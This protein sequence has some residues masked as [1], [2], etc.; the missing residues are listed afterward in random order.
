MSPLSRGSATLR[1]RTWKP[2]RLCSGSA[3]SGA[4]APV[5]YLHGPGR[6]GKSTLLQQFVSEAR[7]AGRIV[8]EVEGRT[9]NPHRTFEQW[10][11]A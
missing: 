1:R 7:E 5:F 6:I 2:S 11:A 4:V 10:L 9:V 3:L 8:A